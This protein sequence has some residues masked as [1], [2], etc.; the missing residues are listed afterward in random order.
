M[1]TASP[2]IRALIPR[3]SDTAHLHCGARSTLA[4]RNLGGS[5]YRWHSHQGVG[6]WVAGATQWGCG[7]TEKKK[8]RLEMQETVEGGQREEETK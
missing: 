5:S 3:V 2:S 6:V 4:Q 1:I 7:F 8:E